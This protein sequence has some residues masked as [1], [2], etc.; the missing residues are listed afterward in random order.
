MAEREKRASS[1]PGL[2]LANAEATGIADAVGSAVRRLWSRGRQEVERAATLGRVRL[3][4]RQLARDRDQ[5]WIR[6][7]K[8]AYRLVESGD[9]EHPALTKAMKRLDE[10]DSRIGDLE[11]KYGTK[12]EDLPDEE[13]ASDSRR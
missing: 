4:L 12:A 13:A 7:G 9:I 1:S 3:E 8:T 2:T 10:I 5:F 6:L 11:K